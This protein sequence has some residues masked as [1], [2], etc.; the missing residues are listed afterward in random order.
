[1]ENQTLTKDTLTELYRLYKIAS[2]RW[3]K[4]NFAQEQHEPR[5]ICDRLV[6]EFFDALADHNT[7]LFSIGID[8]I[9]AFNPYYNPW[10][11]VMEAGDE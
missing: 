11:R 6:A 4:A 10:A 8:D 9:P 1:M 2:V 3:A 7:L 5:K